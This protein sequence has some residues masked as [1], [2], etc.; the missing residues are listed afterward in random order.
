MS[1]LIALVAIALVVVTPMFGCVAI[2]WGF[3]NYPK[4]TG[5]V[6]GG[7]IFALILAALTFHHFFPNCH[8]S[9]FRAVIT[10]C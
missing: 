9:A 1:F 7:L 4:I 6:L 8:F 3:S 2:W 5:L 10:R